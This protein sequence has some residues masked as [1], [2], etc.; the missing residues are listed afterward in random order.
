[1][2]DKWI[3]K[4]QVQGSTGKAYTIAVDAAGGYGCSCPAWIFQ[5]AG[6]KSDC[7]HIRDHKAQ[8]SEAL[9]AEVAA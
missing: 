7:K 1:M 8:I 5:K 6:Q 4:W 9:E 3:Q 2:S